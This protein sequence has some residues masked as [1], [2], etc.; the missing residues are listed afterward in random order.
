MKSQIAKLFS[1][2]DAPTRKGLIGLFALMFVAAGLEMVGVSMFLPLLQLL[3]SPQ[4]AMENPALG[5]MREMIG[6]DSD[7][8][9]IIIFCLS[10]FAFFVFKNVMLAIVIFVQNSFIT[11]HRALYSQALLRH[12]LDKPYVFHLQRNTTELIRNTTLLS[13]RI[14]VKG[15]LPILQ[16]VMELLIISGIGV[17]L[18]LVDPVATVVVGL[19]L[20]GS[21]G[22][23]YLLI[24]HRVQEWGAQV[25]HYDGQ[26]LLWV[27]QALG[28]IK[29]T[30]LYRHE[31]FF[32]EAFAKPS[33][34]Q[35]GFLARST[36]VPHLPR[37]L[38]EV[39]AIGAMALLVVFL[40]NQPGGG[41][42]SIVPK[43]G[44]FAIAAMRLMPSLSKLV[45]ALTNLRDNVAAVDTLYAD[46]NEEAAAGQAPSANKHSGAAFSY[47]R[48]IALEKL[49]YRY[50]ESTET[51]LDGI[52][53]LIERGQSVAFVGASGAGKTTL[54]DLVLGLLEPASGAVRVDGRDIHEDLGGWQSLIGYIPQDIYVTD[55]TLRRNVALG[56][57]DD[58]IDPARIDHALALAQLT[59]FV[60][61][62][63]L[64]LDTVVG[65]RGARL[66]GGQRQRI[67]IA[68]ALYHDP[69]V[70][71]MD[72]A[73][74]ALDGETEK[75]ITTAIDQLSGEKTLIIIAH[76]LSTV[77]HCDLI[78]LLDGGRVVD[79]G[80]FAELAQRNPE[81]RH[82]VEL[83][84]T[85]A[86]ALL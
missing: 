41:I 46:L 55:D 5:M 85:D 80:S 12:Y 30:K 59:A 51:I 20:G 32:V 64:G 79:Q 45:S 62:L 49:A 75:E 9:F 3:V 82:L 57:K 69:E 53:L 81:F 66:S 72:E 16:F 39:V 2:I 4:A 71:V 63:P 26:I 37:L 77:R 73:T 68:R 48:D 11:R 21:V 74:S 40:I 34:A 17:V 8:Q 76:R 1:L 22:I 36:T 10:L 19:V 84:T 47:R 14:F 13:S 67:G 29:E 23:F 6:V 33:N 86:G 65:E 38:I 54:V 15:L 24:R 70:L 78:V 56:K 44:L 60:G 18:M 7:K 43:L 31:N 28:S 25:V 35:A 58:E 27:T 52:D 83:A 42:E 61:D 50:P